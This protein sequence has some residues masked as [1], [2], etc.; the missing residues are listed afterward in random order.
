MSGDARA[1][2]AGDVGRASGAGHARASGAR[3]EFASALVAPFA[4]LHGVGGALRALRHAGERAERARA[5]VLGA[6]RAHV[7]GRAGFALRRLRRARRFVEGALG[8]GQ[9]RVLALGAARVGECARGTGRACGRGLIG[10]AAGGAGRADGCITRDHRLRPRRARRAPV[11]LGKCGHETGGAG[12]ARG[13]TL[14]CRLA[15][16]AW[17]A[18]EGARG[19]EGSAAASHALGRFGIGVLAREAYIALW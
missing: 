8:A 19:R 7:A 6:E 13:C 9:A 2:R 11:A 5:L 1:P 12:R 3:A 17:R 14:G 16:G 15:H 10:K 4:T 18:C